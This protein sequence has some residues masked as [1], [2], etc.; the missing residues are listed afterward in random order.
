MLP[1]SALV[2]SSAR[3]KLGPKARSA[4]ARLAHAA[5]RGADPGEIERLRREFIRTRAEED[6]ENA[7]VELAAVSHDVG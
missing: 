1:K 5:R 3:G 4:R 2:A 7:Q 6:I